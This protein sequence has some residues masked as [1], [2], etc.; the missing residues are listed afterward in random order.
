MYCFSFNADNWPKGQ[1]YF[2]IVSHKKTT[3]YTN[4]LDWSIK[5][6][7]SLFY[8][9][10]LIK[11]IIK[12]ISGNFKTMLHIYIQLCD[13]KKAFNFCIKKQIKKKQ[14]KQLSEKASNF[15]S[16]G[17]LLVNLCKRS[18]F[19]A[20]ISL[21]GRTYSNVT[22]YLLKKKKENY[23]PKGNTGE[24]LVKKRES[25]KTLHQTRFQKLGKEW[26]NSMA[27]L[28]YV[29]CLPF[30]FAIL[31]SF[32]T[33]KKKNRSKN[34]LSILDPIHRGNNQASSNILK[35]LTMGKR[36]I[37]SQIRGR[38]KQKKLINERTHDS[39]FFCALTMTAEL[40]KRYVQP[41]LP[42]LLPNLNDT[43]KI[44]QN[45]AQELGPSKESEYLTKT[46][47]RTQNIK[48][49]KV[50]RCQ[51]NRTIRKKN[52]PHSKSS[53]HLDLSPMN[54]GTGVKK[55]VTKTEKDSKLDKDTS[56]PSLLYHFDIMPEQ[57]QSNTAY[58]MFCYLFVRETHGSVVF[59]GASHNGVFQKDG[60]KISP[61]GTLIPQDMN[62]GSKL[63][64]FMAIRKTD[65]L[66]LAIIGRGS[67]GVVYKCWDL[68]TH[69][70][71]ALKVNDT[72]TI[73]FL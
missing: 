8:I 21:K 29:Y 2:F 72:I 47:K 7:T 13:E 15:L 36:N 67:S 31:S 26:N 18:I 60:F 33:K 66:H 54:L 5:F 14:K 55:G 25:K 42:S 24:F 38:K 65:F 41:L 23:W 20:Q 35:P 22:F 10:S 46:Q 34:K 64:R 32:G 1:T 57:M 45:C 58:H 59:V 19:K 61:N 56:L 44:N 48:T 30:F 40:N 51:V 53:F 43:N 11:K 16:L 39:F 27:I 9:W 69:A 70:F 52:K 37:F 3:Q 50:E 63:D 6:I 71:V 62:D 12:K 28:Q 17:V 73:F 68:R 4:F 49:Q